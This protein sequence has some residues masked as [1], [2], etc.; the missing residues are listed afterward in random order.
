MQLVVGLLILALLGLP[1]ALA[2]RRANELFCLRLRQGELRL[3]RGRLPP[4]LLGDIEDAL[5]RERVERAEIRVVSE[6]RRPR[7]LARG[8]S[9][10]AAQRVRNLVGGYELAQIRA[11]RRRNRA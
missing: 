6:Q 3:V 9:D 8:L 7:V 10:G 1:F 5:R 11:G 4:R 2:L